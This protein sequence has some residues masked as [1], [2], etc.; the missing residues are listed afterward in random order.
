[1]TLW[2]KSVTKFFT[3]YKDGRGYHYTYV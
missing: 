1:M 3:H 2:Q